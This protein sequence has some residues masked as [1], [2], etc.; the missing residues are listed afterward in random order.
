MNA[1]AK[2]I[3]LMLFAALIAGCASEAKR[4]DQSE[5]EIYEAA[6]GYLKSKNYSLAVQN[7]QLLESRFPFGRYAEQA[8]LEIIYAHYRSGDNEAAIA[9]ADRFIRLHPQN[10]KIDYAYYMRGLA[11]FTEG[12]GLLARFVPTDQSVRDPGAATQSFE[13]FRLLLQRFPESPYADD[14]RARMIHLRNR[15]ARYEINVANYYFKR[16]AYLAAAN[17]GRYVVENMPQTPAVADAL[18]VMVQAYLLLGLD[19]LADQSLSVLKRNYPDHSSLDKNGNFVSQVGLDQKR[20]IIN[21]AS[22]G[23]FDQDE[24]PKFDSRDD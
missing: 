19:D 14:A 5:R 13:D 12:E 20:S 18:A 2:L 16:K 1:V 9:A 15:L 8:Q 4:P 17:R 11:N 3:S 10:E 21:R 22:L 24:P 7:L 6:Q 23:L